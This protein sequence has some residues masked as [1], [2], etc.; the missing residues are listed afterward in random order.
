MFEINEPN[1]PQIT[2]EEVKKSL[3]TNEGIILLDVRT[4]GEYTRGRIEGGLNLPLNEVAD[5]IEVIIPNKNDK[6]YV[7]CLS[8]SRSVHAVDAMIKR[9]YT[10]V[11]NVLSGLLAWRAKNY[12]IVA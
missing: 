9:G 6:V 1:V 11:F 12:P 8:G 7:Y 10:N 5:Q 3:D 4:V 2:V